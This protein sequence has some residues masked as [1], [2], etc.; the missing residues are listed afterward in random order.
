LSASAGEAAGGIQVHR[1]LAA[2][3]E[4]NTYV[5][6]DEESRE[7]IVIDPGGEAGAILALLSSERWKATLIVATHAHPDHVAD[8]ARLRRE[9]SVPFCLHHGDAFLLD[10]LPD[11]CSAL[12]IPRIEAPPIDRELVEGDEIALGRH[13]LRVIETPGH[14]PGSVSLHMAELLFS[15]DALFEGSIGRTDLPGG[16]LPVLLRS[17]REKI[18]T[19]PDETR[20]LSGHGEATT[21][22]RERATNPFLISEFREL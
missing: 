21:V 19:L 15:G 17:I 9:L 16:S 10:A 5:L 3:F 6:A 14:S 18:L 11:F 8:A 20:V 7:A 13:R 22:G 12:G 4:E 1:F 2:P